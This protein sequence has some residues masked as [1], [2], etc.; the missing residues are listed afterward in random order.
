MTV[1]VTITLVYGLF[2][3]LVFFRF[4]WIKFSIVWGILTF[5]IGAHLM[6]V[7]VVALR[8]FQPYTIDAH[9]IRPTIQ[10]SPRLPEPTLLAEVMYEPNTPIKKGDPLYKFDTTIYEIR[11]KEQ[12]AALV[13][14]KQNAQALDADVDEAQAAVDEAIANQSYAAEQQKRYANLA[15]QGA[16]RQETLES[17]TQK[18]AAAQS[19]VRQ[20]RDNLAKAQFALNAQID[21]VNA[22]VVE[23]EQRLAEAQYYL[24]Q[25]TIFAPED[26]RIVSQQARPGLVVGGRR[27]G[28]IAAFVVDKEAYLLATFYQEHLKF[29]KPDL[30]AEIAFDMYPGQ[31]FKAKV[32]HVWG[33]TG[34]GQIVPS[35]R[36]PEFLF[37]K[38]QGRFAVEIDVTDPNLKRLPAGAHGAVAIYTGMGKGF[39][40]LRRINIRLYSWANFLFPL[41]I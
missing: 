34:Q 31:I 35:G 29:V 11:V 1:A 17:W 18:L 6:L 33:A 22:R 23:A 40:P 37:P 9:V 2:V 12:E 39:E 3:Y 21:G 8:F 10:I 27:I 30:E 15:S 24:G 5:W 19:Q 4:H 16:G 7:F 14:A 25:T 41:D 38:L 13:N 36:V 26:G 20:A 28:A 32:K